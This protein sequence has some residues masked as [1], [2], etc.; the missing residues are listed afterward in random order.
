MRKLMILSLLFTCFLLCSCSTN[1]NK[2]KAS[3]VSYGMTL[4]EVIE[5]LGKPSETKLST[6]N[7]ETNCYYW[8]NNASN[9]K[10]AKRLTKKGKR[11]YY[12]AV[13]TYTDNI[14]IGKS[15]GIVTEDLEYGEILVYA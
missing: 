12:I 5:I 4:D 11:I 10:E 8:F 7:K 2:T 3:K 14:I 15:A 6:P 9:L 13:I 1:I